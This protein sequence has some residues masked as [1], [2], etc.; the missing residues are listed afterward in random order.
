LPEGSRAFTV[1]V[2]LPEE[3]KHFVEHRVARLLE[4]ARLA[5][6]SPIGVRA[7]G[8]NA[9]AGDRARVVARGIPDDP[10]ALTGVGGR[11]GRLV[12]DLAP[13]RRCSVPKDC[14][15]RHAPGR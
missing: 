7:V 11:E 10:A 9:V 13:R 12:L 8:E 15:R 6:R 1:N 3:G 14:P 4:H 2:W 5:T